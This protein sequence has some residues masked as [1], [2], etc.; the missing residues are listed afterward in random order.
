MSTHLRQTGD[1][2]AIDYLDSILGEAKVH[3]INP[4][5]MQEHC[6]KTQ[7]GEMYWI[8]TW[9]ANTQNREADKK[10]LAV[11]ECASPDFTR[12]PRAL[13]PYGTETGPRPSNNS[14]QSTHD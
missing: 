9:G 13:R 2:R 4:F 11:N 1:D 8:K 10:G 5:F 12:Y 7:W 14:A 3:F 6:D